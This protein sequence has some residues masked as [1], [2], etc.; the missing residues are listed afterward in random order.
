MTETT[1]LFPDSAEPLSNDDRATLDVTDV[2]RQVSGAVGSSAGQTGAVRSWPGSTPSDN[3]H[4][5][6]HGPGGGAQRLSAM[7]L[8]EL[9]RLAQSL[10][11]TGIA[12]MRKGQLVAAIEEARRARDADLSGARQGSAPVA[13]EPAV[14]SIADRANQSESSGNSVKR[15]ASAG[16]G[17]NRPFEQDAMES[18]GSG[19]LS[20][21]STDSTGLAAASPATGHETGP[22]SPAPASE[23]L[24]PQVTQP[25]P[26]GPAGEPVGESTPVSGETANG[27]GF[28]TKQEAISVAEAADD[29]GAA[30]RELTAGDTAG[31]DTATDATGLDGGQDRSGQDGEAASARRGDAGS[32]RDGQRGDRR[33]RGGNGRRDDQ[34]RAAA[35]GG[36]DQ[37]R[38]GG[39]GDQQRESGQQG[40]GD[41]QGDRKSVV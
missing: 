36:A 12:R 16:A 39:R 9:Q 7:L 29:G 26:G 6:E 19:Q 3:T 31:Q 17:A 41:Q 10:G 21:V 15:N 35:E 34:G 20:M 40:R 30:G 13:A 38:D 27:A 2:A 23:S 25:A 8:P 1:N 5:D 33:G 22:T 11:I 14:T 4:S 37:V 18:E 32:R 28:V 24:V